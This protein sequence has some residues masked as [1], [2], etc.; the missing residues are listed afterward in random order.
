MSGAMSSQSSPN[1]PSNEPS[2]EPSD[3]HDGHEQLVDPLLGPNK[4]LSSVSPAPAQ[5]STDSPNVHASLIQPGNVST[6]PQLD[7]AS[8]PQ[9]SHIDAEAISNE[10]PPPA[11]DYF[12][13]TAY[14]SHSVE[15]K[16]ESPV[17]TAAQTA[18][19]R[20]TTRSS[21]NTGRTNPEHF[22]PD[23]S[24]G[25]HLS[26]Q[27]Q[28]IATAS[29][30][31]SSSTSDERMPDHY[32]RAPRRSATEHPQY[33]NQS[34]SALSA[35]VHPEVH[36]APYDSRPMPGRQ[37][38]PNPI[39]LFATATTSTHNSGDER[40]A[41]TAGN[42]PIQTPH[43]FSPRAPRYPSPIVGDK[44]SPIP[45]PYLHPVQPQV[46]KETNKATRDIDTSS[47]RKTINQYE[48][49]YE[50]GKGTHGKVKLA[51]DIATND[52]VAI[53]IVQRYSKKRRLGKGQGQE[54]KV[55][56]EIA[57]LKKALHP[58]VVG[59][60]EVIDD[61]DLH[62]IYL[63]LEF[64]EAHDVK[65]REFGETEIV[66]MEYR[67]LEREMEGSTEVDPK[68]DPDRLS[69]AA[70]KRRERIAKHRST[71]LSRINSESDFWSLEYA[72]DSGGEEDRSSNPS[73]EPASL[74]RQSNSH[75]V[76]T[77]ER[78]ISSTPSPE[79]PEASTP[80]GA[81]PARDW[82][83][84]QLHHNETPSEDEMSPFQAFIRQNQNHEAQ[85]PHSQGGDAVRK[86][87]LAES[88]SSQLSAAMEALVDEDMRYVP[89]LTL[90]ESRRAFRD[91]LLGLEYLHY[92]GIIHRDIKPENLLRKADHSV[93]ISD[94]GVSYLGK[95]IRD[96]RESEETSDTESADYHE[97]EADLAKTVG[98]PAF[99]APE[100]C[101]LN[102]TADKQRVTGQID[103]WALGVTLFC[104]VYARLP[105]QAYNEFHMMRKIDEDEVFISRRRLKAVDSHARSRP[106]SLGPYL[107]ASK[108]HRLPHDLLYDEIDDDLYDLLKRLLTKDPT[109][110]ITVKEIKHH[111]WVLGEI[112]QPLKWL[113]DT[114]P[115][116]FTQGKKIEISGEDVKEAVIPLRLIERAKSV[117]K[118]VTAVFGSRTN[119]RKRGESSAASSEASSGS[120]GPL[121][122]GG[123]FANQEHSRSE[124]AMATMLRSS[125]E[126]LHH[127]NHAEHPLSQ[128][129][130]ASPE[131][132]S[133][134]RGF[135]WS[136]SHVPSLGSDV[137]G[138]YTQGRP[139]MPDRQESVMSTAGSVRTV[140]QSDFPQSDHF[141]STDRGGDEALLNPHDPHAPYSL[142]HML[143]E[144]GRNLLRSVRS[145]DRSNPEGRSPSSAPLS[146]PA[147]HSEALQSEPSVAISSTSVSGHLSNV[148]D[149][150]A[151]PTTLSKKSSPVH[152]DDLSNA[153]IREFLARRHLQYLEQTLSPESEEQL[154]RP[155]RRESMQSPDDQRFPLTS[156]THQHERFRPPI[157][158][159][160][161]DDRIGSGMSRETSFPSAPQSV[162]S[163]DSSIGQ[164]L[165]TD[166]S[167]SP[168]RIGSHESAKPRQA[169]YH[170]ASPPHSTPRAL[171]HAPP[172]LTGSYEQQPQFDEGGE[173]DED[174]S[175]SDDGVLIMNRTKSRVVETPK[176][177]ARSG[178]L[179]AGKRR[180]SRE[181]SHM[182]PKGD[183]NDDSRSTR[184]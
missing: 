182:T 99:Y 93:K 174:D 2:E 180:D 38:A 87:S 160:S 149:I 60:I 31:H 4:R 134:E 108:D 7:D 69:R 76:Q 92:Q 15:S 51:R 132:P 66:I 143:G 125:R 70:N 158:S 135:N 74:S 67:R 120:P 184:E 129:L 85:M 37:H 68:S 169:S 127:H 19:S 145:R 56:K 144:A 71:P 102:F 147:E 23:S 164:E 167:S 79:R 150:P 82:S 154:S 88:T 107:V 116:R 39:G 110:R 78:N 142:S 159:T 13:P 117:A 29:I 16:N 161:S 43:L 12:T 90:S 139:N 130:T 11:D 101:S 14:L 64:C 34:L 27:R 45:S 58:N 83:A 98:T 112:H 168:S 181:L 89:L 183:I 163:A 44:D 96:G 75:D 10:R 41:R 46:P 77:P 17:E 94:F 20:Q 40:Q 122:A 162:I 35:Q 54:D 62:K 176:L 128:S 171:H 95:P 48:I 26:A 63:V 166:E 57:I 6:T 3:Y 173:T 1:Q 148:R 133:A 33:P 49:L 47:G 113:D 42:T 123:S 177:S 25:Q 146:H 22:F 80:R 8:A 121:S 126:Q 140:T 157:S 131:L 179:S 55:K 151:S 59:M 156:P 137:Q 109:K 24:L 106:S 72:A 30:N 73:V 111:P 9:R 91:A 114:D 118:K 5:V 115:A 18:L 97:E 21:D 84:H 100:L 178:S 172:I 32:R 53:K 170:T 81:Q 138:A 152:G 175:D 65:W 50:I 141:R 28:T 153:D 105:F 124:D 165:G 119:P 155:G 36:H 136:T 86:P 103:V 104:F 61:P 52:P